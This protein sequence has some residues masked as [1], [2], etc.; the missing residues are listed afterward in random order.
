MLELYRL[1]GPKS[2]CQ[3]QKRWRQRKTAHTLNATAVAT[4][5]IMTAIIE[6]NQTDQGIRIPEALQPYMGG[7]E[8]IG[9]N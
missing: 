7:Q 3:N 8:Y 5:R 9:T 6:N 1:S 2:R 4:S